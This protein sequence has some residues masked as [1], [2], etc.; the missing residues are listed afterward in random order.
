LKYYFVT[1][2]FYNIVLV[3]VQKVVPAT[4]QYIK[5][6]FKIEKI[7]FGVIFLR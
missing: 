6:L 1:F 3:L 7:N 2:L 5:R 4:K